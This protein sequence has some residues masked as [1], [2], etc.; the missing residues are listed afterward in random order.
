MPRTTPRA[1]DQELSRN[2]DYATNNRQEEQEMRDLVEKAAEIVNEIRWLRAQQCV[3]CGLS[4]RNS[5]GTH[6]WRGWWVFRRPQCE[7]DPVGWKADLEE[8]E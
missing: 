2:T 8:E 4:Y 5:S 7:Y 6:D 3:R 1:S